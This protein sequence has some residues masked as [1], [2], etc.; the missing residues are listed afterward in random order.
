MKAFKITFSKTIGMGDESLVEVRAIR[1][2][3]LI[4]SAS[5]WITIHELIIESNSKNVENRVSN[6]MEAPWRLRKWILHIERLK[7]GISRWEVNHIFRE[8]NQV[9]DCLTKERVQRQED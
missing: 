2:A 4:F 5:K 8:R 9:A 6:P 1:E 3:F 7:K